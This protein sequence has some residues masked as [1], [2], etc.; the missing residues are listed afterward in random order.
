MLKYKFFNRAFF[1]FLN[2]LVGSRNG[3]IIFAF[4]GGLGGGANKK[5]R[6]VG[7]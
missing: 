5:Y 1:T 7:K 2:A 4:C 6:W 3:S